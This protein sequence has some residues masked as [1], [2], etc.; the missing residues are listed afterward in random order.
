MKANKRNIAFLAVLLVLAFCL[1]NF[2]F[3]APAYNNGTRHETAT[4][5]SAQA[6]SYYGTT[7]SYQSL[8]GLSAATLKTTLGSLMKS[9][10][11]KTV[12]YSSLPTHWQYTDTENGATGGKMLWFYCDVITTA[13]SSREHVWPKSRGLFY[14]SGAGS[15]IHHLR[16]SES[17]MNSTRSNHT[18]G[19]V[20]SKGITHS[21]RSHGGRVV[22]WYN[23]S[24]SA[25][26]CNGL[27]EPLDSVK[28]DV[29]RIFL[30]LYTTYPENTNLFTKVS[31]SGSGNNASD[32]NKAIESMETLL[33]WCALDP[34][35]TW[36]MERNDITQTIQGNR[37]VFIDYPEY[38]WLLFSQPIPTDL[39]TPSGGTGDTPTPTP[40][41]TSIPTSTPE[42]THTPEPTYTPTPIPTP[43]PI[44][45]PVPEDR[46]GDAN[47]DGKITA[48]DAAAILRHI[49]KL[50]V[51]SAQELSNACVTGDA[52][53]T[54][55]DAAKILRWIVRLENAL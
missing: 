32:G 31:A 5:V 45:T 46:R 10:L 27:V 35:D 22:L 24:Y 1:C 39:I 51:L 2:A 23:A 18:M 33:E 6:Q 54:A 7:Y 14:E 50:E 25:N 13:F 15:D 21:T 20:K 52:V 16:P 4:A 11:T 17:A 29:A 41:H 47:G 36:E 53:P 8:S 43:T 26:N 9:T 28:G 19:N 55:A 30:Y 3:A 44:L 34:V 42:P 12:S 40:T 48:A 38:A 37:N 49:V